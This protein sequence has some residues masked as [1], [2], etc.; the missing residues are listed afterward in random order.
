MSR[1]PLGV[2]LLLGAL[3]CEGR[4]LTVFDLQLAPLAGTGGSGG[5]GGSSGKDS[6]GGAG[7]SPGGSSGAPVAGS[8]GGS[9]GDGGDAS[10]AGASGFTAMPCTSPFDCGL[11]WVCEKAG[12][13]AE[14]GECIPWPSGFC[15]RDPDPVCGCDGVTYWNDCT[16]LDAKVQLAGPGPCRE[17]ARPCDIGAD[18]NVPYASCSHLIPSG[19]LCG[20]STGA[21]W[22]LPPQCMPSADNKRWRECRPPDQGPP[23]P[24][25]DTCLAISFERPFAELHRGEICN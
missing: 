4:E 10:T 19:D 7:D 9:G 3:A 23:G 25:V 16:R 1:A 13:N 15:S 22:V 20:H 21:C 18:C 24:C 2:A 8:F 11:S 17:S 6:S 14:V 5:S 12:C